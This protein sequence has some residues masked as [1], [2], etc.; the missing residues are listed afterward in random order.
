MDGFQ[1]A[2]TSLAIIAIVMLMILFVC[3]LFGPKASAWVCSNREEK[4][5]LSKSKLFN[6][7]GYLVNY[8]FYFFFCASLSYIIIYSKKK[9]RFILVLK[10]Y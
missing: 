7:N 1:A 10:Y 4:I 9:K 8:F 3:H 2:V 6:A 5:G